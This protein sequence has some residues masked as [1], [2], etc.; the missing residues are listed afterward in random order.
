MFAMKTLA[1]CTVLTIAAALTASAPALAQMGTTSDMPAQSAAKPAPKP[2]PS[3]PATAEV[4]LHGQTITIH[5]NAPSMRGRKIMGGLV[6]Y[7]KVWR[8]G[9][10]PA[11]TLITPINLRIGRLK[12]PAGTYTLFTLPTD[13]IWKLIVSKKTGE[14]GIPYPE[15]FD[16]GR[17]DMRHKKLP[18]PQEVM[19]ISFENTQPD[20]TELHIKW[21]TTNQWVK[22][23]AAK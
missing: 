14:W 17:T 2:L 21:E 13:G 8:T 4:S 23:A 6:P 18:A 10:N 22:I 7:D 3:P 11:T 15:G 9:A 1:R 16:L 20:S 12:V 19:S 5:Y